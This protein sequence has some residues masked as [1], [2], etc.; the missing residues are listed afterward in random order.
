MKRRSMI[1]TRV[2]MAVRAALVMA[3]AGCSVG[4]GTKIGSTVKS[5]NHSG[6]TYDQ[7]FD[8]AEAAL[9]ELG[10][11][12]AANRVTGVIEGEIPPYRVKAILEK[13]SSWLKLEGIEEEQGAWKRGTGK[14]EWSLS[15]LDGT[16]RYRQGAATLQEAVDDWSHA[17]NRR[18]P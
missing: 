17:I 9:D 1:L 13:G 4:Y 16:F 11:V 12:T 8:G 5:I 7:I 2:I 10:V 6:Y 3:V 15:M 14:G 18:I